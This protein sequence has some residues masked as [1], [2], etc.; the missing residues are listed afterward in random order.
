VGLFSLT[1][2]AG[3]VEAKNPKERNE[4]MAKSASSSLPPSGP[5]GRTPE[6][7]KGTG[8]PMGKEEKTRRLKIAYAYPE[9]K[10]TRRGR[11]DWG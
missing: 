10:K 5:P 3:G 1:V 4:S 2:S 9:K 8:D 11:G 7:K 6:N